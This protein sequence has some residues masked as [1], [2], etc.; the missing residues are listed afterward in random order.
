MPVEPD[1]IRN[2]SIFPEDAAAL[3]DVPSADV[4]EVDAAEALPFGNDEWPDDYI[5]QQYLQALQAVEEVEHRVNADTGINIAEDQTAEPEVSLEPLSADGTAPSGDT[6]SESP[7]H[8][9]LPNVTPRQIIEAAIFVGG[10]S[11]TLK[12]ISMLFR[13]EFDHDFIEQTIDSINMQ[14]AEE[15]RPYEIT[16]GEGGYRLALCSEF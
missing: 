13:S 8:P 1:D 15:Q 10:T 7:Q 5:E 16:F 6:P 12:R 11:L 4:Y 14:Y 3:N 9:G 2:I